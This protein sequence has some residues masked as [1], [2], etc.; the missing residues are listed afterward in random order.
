MEKPNMPYGVVKNL[1]LSIFII[2]SINMI[3]SHK[4]YRNCAVKQEYN[5]FKYHN[6]YPVVKFLKIW[7]ESLSNILLINVFSCKFPEV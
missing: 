6:Q 1:N 5:L 7:L 3:Y 2:I 4:I